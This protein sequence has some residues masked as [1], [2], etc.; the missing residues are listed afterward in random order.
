L[1]DKVAISAAGV[2]EPTLQAAEIR[3][4]AERPTHD[5]TA[6]DLYLRALAGLG[7]GLPI[8]RRH[9]GRALADV[10]GEV[11]GGSAAH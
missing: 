10:E 4:S 11:L 3:R 9:D 2:I 7:S 1:Q 5:P 8:A 6:Y